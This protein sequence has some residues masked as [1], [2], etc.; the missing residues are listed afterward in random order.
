L[1][2]EK[3]INLLKEGGFLGF[4]TSNKYAI[5]D[6]GKKLREF[7][8]NNCKIVSII[9]VSNL[10]VFKDAS[11]YPY[12]IIL[13]KTK[14]NAGNIIKGFKTDNELNLDKGE[15]EINQDDIKNSAAKN[16]VVKE[17]LEFLKKIEDISV[18]LGEI[19][20]I[21]E[22]IHTGNVRK[23]LIVD[24]KIDNSCKKL[25]AGRDC[26]RYWFKWNGKYIR[27]D[28]NLINK[29]KGE[30]GNLIEEKYFEKPKILLREIASN[31][32][33][34][35][36][37]EKYY[38]LNKVYSV[39]SL[40]QYNLEYIL[41]LLNSK[42][43]SYYF[44]N[45]FEEAHVRGGYLQFKKTYTSQIPI[46]KIDFSKSAEKKKHDE[47]VKLAEK[48]L[49][50]NKQIQSIPENSEKWKSIEREIEKV[51]REIDEKVYELC[52]LTG[53]EIKIIE[54]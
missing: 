7:I 39:Q 26:H 4:I 23:K 15:V 25:L 29:T 17:E 37:D 21:K 11:T 31:I 53:E 12:V 14:N 44:R 5:A 22:T 2:F 1:F 43:L 19:A 13:Q 9:D 48:M 40:G 8:L 52:G 49:D 42:L 47:F 50:F 27:Y 24:E 3:S 28:K 16:F 10:Q 36:D 46:Y 54:K 30:Y 41:V 32:E 18:R 34:C 20:T 45:K 35:Y 51:D 6:Y 38:S 33:C